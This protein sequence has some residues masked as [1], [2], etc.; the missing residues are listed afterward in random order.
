M[1]KM[2]NV[3]WTEDGELW[4]A[5]IVGHIP[6][7][8]APSHDEFHAAIIQGAVE[9]HLEDSDELMQLTPEDL[10]QV[11]HH[12]LIPEGGESD[13]DCWHWGDG[14]GESHVAFTGMR[15]LT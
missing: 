3:Y 5:V 2:I 14:S 10:P 12:W 1:T 11:K 13:P 7:S 8:E 4:G 6:L 15:F 9:A